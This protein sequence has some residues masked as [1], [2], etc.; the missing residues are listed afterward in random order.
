[1]TTHTKNQNSGHR[2]SER[3][4]RPR[5]LL[6]LAILAIGSLML[7]FYLGTRYAAT[8]P[9]PTVQAKTVIPVWAK[10]EERT[11]SEGLAIA[12]TTKAGETAPISARTNG[13]PVLVYQNQKPGNVLKAG[14][15]IGII[16]ADPVFVLEGPLPLYRDLNLG[17]NGDD[18]LAF[19]KALNSAGYATAQSGTVTEDTLDAVTRLHR[20]HLTGVP[21]EG[22]TS[23]ARSNYAILPGGSHTVTAVAAVGQ[24][25]SDGNPIASVET[26]EPYVESSVELA[27]ANKL[28]VGDRI[29]LR[30]STG[31][32]EGTITSIGELQNDPSKGAA[33]SVRFSA[34]DPSKLTPGQ[35]ASITS[36]GNTST[37]LAV[38]TTAVRQDSQGT[39][40]LVEKGGSSTSTSK[41][42]PATERVNVEV[43]RTAGGYAAINANLSTGQ[44]VLVS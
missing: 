11:V 41:D 36:K 43:L 27:V 14:D 38:P 12:G 33:K 9:D 13:E 44:K 32:V 40:V 28:K 18:V 17:D 26:S 24:L 23:I 30:T 16:G 1:M 15:F 22:V 10:V 29:S 31:S 3:I 21:S 2:F 37:T 39:Y 8:G 6:L 20:A 4:A 5:V 35:S 19:Q 42:A 25:I 34:D 7:S